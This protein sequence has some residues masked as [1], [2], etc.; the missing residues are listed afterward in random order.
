MPEFLLL[1]ATVILLMVAV[2]LVRILRGP[3]DVDRLM[4]VQ[5][6]GTGGIAALL[7]LGI[8]TSLPGAVDVA[9]VLALLAA[10]AAVIFV[11]SL[12]SP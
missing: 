7:L 3:A 8:A 11:T 5:L 6:L 9:L 1:A 2:G 4:A 10:F 12:D